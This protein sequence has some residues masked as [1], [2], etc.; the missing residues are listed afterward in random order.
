MTVDYTDADPRLHD[1][2]VRAFGWRPELTKGQPHTIDELVEWHRISRGD[3]TDQFEG[4]ANV[5][6]EFVY[7]VE[8]HHAETSSYD[9]PID[10]HPN[11]VTD[12]GNYISLPYQYPVFDI[13]TAYHHRPD[14]TA[15][16]AASFDPRQDSA[17]TR[18]LRRLGTEDP[19]LLE[20][21]HQLGGNFTGDL[22]AKHVFGYSTEWCVRQSALADWIPGRL[23]A[24]YALHD[25]EP[26]GAYLQGI[27]EDLAPYGRATDLRSPA[28]VDA[29]DRLA[30]DLIERY[31]KS[32]R[33]GM[34]HELAMHVYNSPDLDAVL[35]LYT[36]AGAEYVLATIPER[37]EAGAGAYR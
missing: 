35:G 18:M 2:V 12:D 29:L 26:D 17:R 1:A 20:L 10:T 34:S 7:E 9:L 36:T 32:R 11:D 15:T 19:R 31:T 21:K 24:N 3:R 33:A 37:Y 23:W 13:V 4:I 22:D 14:Y 25:L 27:Q 30:A 28:Q 16:L 6:A 8:Q 5:I